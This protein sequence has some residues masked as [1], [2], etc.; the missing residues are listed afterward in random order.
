MRVKR[1]VLKLNDA[2]H[3]HHSSYDSAAV[4]QLTNF[5]FAKGNVSLN[6]AYLMFPTTLPAIRR[7]CYNVLTN[8][9]TNIPA[10]QLT[11]NTNVTKTV[12]IQEFCCFRG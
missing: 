9:L 1:V 6:F 3:H 10:L 4:E 8:N 7:T 5:V 12:S 2:F 11:K